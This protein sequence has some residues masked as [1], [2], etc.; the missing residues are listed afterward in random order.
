MKTPP[1]LCLLQVSTSQGGQSSPAEQ[2]PLESMRGPSIYQ[3]TTEFRPLVADLMEVNVVGDD[4]HQAICKIAKP[5]GCITYVYAKGTRLPCCVWLLFPL[6]QVLVAAS[7]VR[8]SGPTC[9]VLNHS[10]CA[11][12]RRWQLPLPQHWRGNGCGSCSP[13]CR[14]AG[15]LQQAC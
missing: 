14:P 10:A 6:E 15:K 13:A 3:P 7:F 12:F 8:V 4:S 11:C 9:C 5:L 2:S 1:V